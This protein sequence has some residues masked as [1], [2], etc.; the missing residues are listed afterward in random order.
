MSNEGKPH[1]FYEDQKNAISARQ[2]ALKIMQPIYKIIDLLPKCTK[3][4]ILKKY[5]E[6]EYNA[7]V[8]EYNRM[9]ESRKHSSVKLA[10]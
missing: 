5:T 8:K 4:E 7:A 9:Q 6:K 1:N 2:A 3:E 10:I